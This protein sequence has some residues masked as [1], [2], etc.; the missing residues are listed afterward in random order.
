MSWSRITL[1]LLLA[2]P[3]WGLEGYVLSGGVQ[4]D[5]DGG[6]AF[7][8]AGSLGLN[9]KAWLSA[10]VSSASVEIGRGFDLDT[11]SADIGI[12]YHFDPIGIRLDVGYWG[13]DDILDSRDS[14][15][16]LYWQSDRVTVS[17]NYEYRDFDFSIP[18]TADFQARAFSFDATGLGLSARFRIN[19]TLS[20]SARSMEYDYSVRL[21]RTDNLDIISFFSTSR[22]SL[23]NSLDDRLLGGG[24]DLS[25]GDQQWGLDYRI[26]DGA[27]DGSTTRST[28]VNFLTPVG[29]RLD[30]ELGVGIDDSDLYGRATFYSLFF[31]FYGGN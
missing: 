23:L 20:I 17:A 19:D 7:A 5:S 2:S 30:I 29:R 31:Y 4:A 26:S 13:D 14:R 27:V 22:L 15:L 3:A 21:R 25:I 12:D 9:K 16:S 11:R 6:T 1:L 28:T 10:S 18:T 8:A 24:L